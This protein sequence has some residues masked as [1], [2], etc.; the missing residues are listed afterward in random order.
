MSPNIKEGKEVLVSSI[1]Y[2]FSK[3]KS[4]DVVAFWHFDKLLIKRIKRVKSSHYL[5]EGDNENDSLKIG[6]KEKR[7]IIGKVIYIL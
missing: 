5:V 2:I 6:W 3:P 4:G 1:P 7:D